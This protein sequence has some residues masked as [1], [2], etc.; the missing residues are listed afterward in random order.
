VNAGAA[1]AP[2]QDDYEAAAAQDGEAAFC[3]LESAPPVL[4]EPLL[5]RRRFEGAEA[6]EFS[7]LQLDKEGARGSRAAAQRK[8]TQRSRPNDGRSRRSLG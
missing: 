3:R 5:P 7:V 8:R 4:P 2:P 6:W 1:A